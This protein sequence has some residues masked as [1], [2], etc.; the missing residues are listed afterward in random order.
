MND[1][2]HGLSDVF[3]GA[4]VGIVASRLV[5]RLGG[6]RRLA[7]TRS[8]LGLRLTFLGIRGGMPSVVTSMGV[9]GLDRI[10]AG[11]WTRPIP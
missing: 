7:P 3:A 9:A 5:D 11:L 10:E 2:K 8:G 1:D 6:A 4:A